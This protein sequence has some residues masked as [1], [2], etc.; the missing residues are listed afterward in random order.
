MSHM[1]QETFQSTPGAAYLS[2]FPS[3]HLI[4]LVSFAGP[5][6]CLLTRIRP[7]SGWHK[8]GHYWPKVRVAHETGFF[9]Q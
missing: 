3:V 2:P 1:G 5:L 7:S 4:L 8:P 6:A 9:D